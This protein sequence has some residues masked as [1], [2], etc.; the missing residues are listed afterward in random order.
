MPCSILRELDFQTGVCLSTR[1]IVRRGELRVV[2]CFISRDMRCYA[3]AVNALLGGE[4]QETYIKK[5]TIILTR[6]LS[7]KKP[8]EQDRNS[9]E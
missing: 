8:I 5:I 7:G 2:S 3:E 6:I 1:I 4:A 9:D